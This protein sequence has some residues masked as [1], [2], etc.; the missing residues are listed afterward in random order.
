MAEHSSLSYGSGRYPSS[1]VSA[2]L[3]VTAPA[4]LALKPL[5][6]RCIALA[7]KSF[8]AQSLLSHA[9]YFLVESI[10]FFVVLLVPRCWRVAL[11]QCLKRFLNREFGSICH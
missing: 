10:H 7:L 11:A 9:V 8:E 4:A 6:R 3:T 1:F 5:F 2:L